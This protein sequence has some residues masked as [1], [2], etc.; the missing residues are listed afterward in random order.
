MIAIEYRIAAFSPD[1]K[2]TWD[3]SDSSAYHYYL[4]ARRRVELID[5]D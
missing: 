3:D 4:Q 1:A 2:W 5:D